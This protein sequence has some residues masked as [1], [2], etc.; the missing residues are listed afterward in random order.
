[1]R[2][3]NG[4]IKAIRYA[5]ENKVPFFGICLGMQMAVVEACQSLLKIENA[6][7]AEFG[8]NCTPV[9]SKMTVWEKDG[10]KQI[11]PDNGDMGTAVKNALDSQPEKK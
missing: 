8:G 5:R 2:G 1:M 10:K 7:S 11:R 4:K 6:S 3:I 9:I